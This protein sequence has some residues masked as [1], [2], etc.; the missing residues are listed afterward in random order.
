[1]NK[2]DTVSRRFREI[3]PREWR[4]CLYCCARAVFLRRELLLAAGRQQGRRE[5]EVV[6]GKGPYDGRGRSYPYP[7]A[8]RHHQPAGPR[9]RL[10]KTCRRAVGAVGIQGRISRIRRFAYQ[11]DRQRITFKFLGDVQLF[12]KL[13][14]SI[15]QFLVIQIVVLVNFEC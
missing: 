12:H 1:M 7:A 5:E 3:A 10:R 9:A 15:N 4:R 6:S 14:Q 8:V 2:C 13:G 11:F